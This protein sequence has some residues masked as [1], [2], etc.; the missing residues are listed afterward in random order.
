MCE[1]SST[2]HMLEK[3]NLVGGAR[4]PFVD[5]GI[6][7]QGVAESL[8]EAICYHK[9]VCKPT[10]LKPVQDQEQM[11]LYHVLALA[12]YNCFQQEAAPR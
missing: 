10:I 8:F 9:F 3:T 1:G 4:S 7:N 2:V 6:H 5:R 12:V 11:L